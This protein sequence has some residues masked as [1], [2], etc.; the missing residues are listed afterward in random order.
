MRRIQQHH[1]LFRSLG[2][3]L[4]LISLHD[5]FGIKIKGLGFGIYDTLLLFSGLWLVYLTAGALKHSRRPR[6]LL[7][8]KRFFYLLLLFYA[9]VSFSST[10]QSKS[11]VEVCTWFKCKNVAVIL[12]IDEVHASHGIGG[13]RNYNDW[14]FFWLTPD[15]FY[16]KSLGP[17][18]ERYPSLK[19]TLGWVP[20]GY[21]NSSCSWKNGSLL[22]ESHPWDDPVGRDWTTNVLAKLYAT[23]RF[24]E[25]VAHGYAHENFNQ[26][27]PAQVEES[28]VKIQNAFNNVT[29][30]PATGFNTFP[31][32][33]ER[34]DLVPIFSKNGFYHLGVAYAEPPNSS[35]V[36]YLVQ[37]N[38]RIILL[39]YTLKMDDTYSL[40]FFK[41]KITDIAGTDKP[42]RIVRMFMHALPDQSCSSKSGELLTDSL[43]R[44]YAKLDLL[45]S[46]LVSNYSG[47]GWFT[48]DH[49]AAHYFDLVN[50][51]YVANVYDGDK[52]LS[53]DIFTTGKE[54]A[55]S[56][57]MP[58]TLSIKPS[59]ERIPVNMYC[60]SN[61][62]TYFFTSSDFS[63]YPNHFSIDVPLTAGNPT[64]VACT[65][66]FNR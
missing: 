27:S 33:E 53:F 12:S 36:S 47:V 16:K 13:D 34:L 18:L 64:G 56:D 65:V 7:K 31:F 54:F 52:Q 63:I 41:E 57:Q 37:N 24:D 58:I 46:F 59:K 21:T 32:F 43:E 29:G 38:T 44:N 35:T 23:G 49:A 28:L 42:F 17:L 3:S 51:I 30:H 61:D 62:R 66:L 48:T 60:T 45:L 50:N 2:L 25:F 10:T 8:Y 40:N 22:L 6:Y 1:C 9:L 20:G 15:G 5:I 11:S 26:L 19:V 14:G 55:W 4:I 39:P